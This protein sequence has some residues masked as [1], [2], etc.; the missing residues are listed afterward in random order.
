[1]GRINLYED[2][3]LFR[4]FDPMDPFQDALLD[5]GQLRM[6]DRVS[7]TKTI[8]LFLPTPVFRILSLTKLS[9]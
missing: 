3:V 8:N 6:M 7:Y 1:M 2:K 5:R 4:A 9:N